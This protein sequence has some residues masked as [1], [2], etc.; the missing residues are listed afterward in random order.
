MKWENFLK[1]TGNLPVIE[2]ELLLTGVSEP[3]AI[4]VQI[5]RWTRTG[6][7]IK[8]KRGVYLLSQEYRKVDVYEP[9]LAVLLKTPSYISL[10]KSLE[11]YGLIPEAVPVYTCITTGRT[12]RF[13]SPVGIFD[14]KHIKNSLFWGYNSVTVNKQTVFFALPEKAL[15]DFFFLKGTNSPFGFIEELR[16]QN[17]EKINLERLSRFAQQFKKPGMLN[18][19][20]MLNNYICSQREKEKTL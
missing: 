19:A 2:T 9:Y 6:K 17:L 11:Y 3:D 4:N 18:I 15:L 14:Y 10:E 16:L 20:K 13:V 1:I 5:S 12:T 8:V 7:L